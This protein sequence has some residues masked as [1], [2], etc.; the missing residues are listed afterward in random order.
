VG[1][2]AQVNTAAGKRPGSPAVDL[3]TLP[4]RPPA[5]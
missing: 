2:A 5:L 4:P 3:L 1:I